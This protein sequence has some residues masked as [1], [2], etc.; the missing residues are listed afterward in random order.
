MREWITKLATQWVLNGNLQLRKCK[1]LFAHSQANKNQ[2]TTGP[3]PVAQLLEC[4][5]RGTG[6]HGFDPGPQHTKV[7]KM[8]LDRLAPRLTGRPS[9]RIM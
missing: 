3:A 8:V 9:V 7:V 6:G 1:W 2:T 4:L 5:L